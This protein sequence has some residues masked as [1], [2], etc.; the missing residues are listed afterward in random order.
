MWWTRAKQRVQQ[1]TDKYFAVSVLAQHCWATVNI[2]YCNYCHHSLV[3]TAGITWYLSLRVLHSVSWKCHPEQFQLRRSFGKS[4]WKS[5]EGICNAIDGQWSMDGTYDLWQVAY[6][7]RAT[8]QLSRSE[9]SFWCKPSPHPAPL[10][11]PPTPSIIASADLQYKPF[12]VVICSDQIN[13]L[14]TIPCY[15]RPTF[16]SQ[17]GHSHIIVS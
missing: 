13:I 14:L 9:N 7:P 11:T 5:R 17:L 15:V 1:G 6:H 3:A 12:A 2:A 8:G 4:R 10:P 16:S